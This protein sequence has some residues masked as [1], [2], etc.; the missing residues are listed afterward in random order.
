MKGCITV[1]TFLKFFGSKCKAKD[2]IIED[3]VNKNVRQAL[4]FIMYRSSVRF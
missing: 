2:Q 3:E 1:A 4:F